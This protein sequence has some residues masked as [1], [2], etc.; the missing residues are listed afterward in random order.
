MV[1]TL[2]SNTLGKGH[3]M[4]GGYKKENLSYNNKNTFFI[5]HKTELEKTSQ[6]AGVSVKKF[7][8]GL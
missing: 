5:K 8:Q 6:E 4:R 2:P 3:L 1:V 7:P